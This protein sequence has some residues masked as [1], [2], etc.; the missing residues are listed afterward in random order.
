MTNEVH[1]LIGRHGK[2]IVSD[3]PV[4]K[5]K[6]SPESLAKLYQ[7]GQ[8]DFIY[9]TYPERLSLFTSQRARTEA[10]GKAK[11]AGVLG[12]K[13][14]PQSQDD[15]L[16]GNK[17]P[18]LAQI[19][20][21]Q[22]FGLDLYPGEFSDKAYFDAEKVKSG[23]GGKVCTEFGLRNLDATQHE[24]EDV[25]PF[26]YVLGKAGN[27]LREAIELA[28]T[29]KKDLIQLISHSVITDANAALLVSSD[30]W[31]HNNCLVPDSGAY[32]GH[33][34]EEDFGVLNINYDGTGVRRRKAHFVRRDVAFPV[35][36]I[37]FMNLTS[38]FSVTHPVSLYSP[39]VKK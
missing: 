35:D 6:I 39:P 9:S 16:D 8:R 31:S 22:R 11:F 18:Q 7:E 4:E 30:I 15:V 2:K 25:M 36:I 1:I 27:V 34:E 38:R 13:P 14:V 26:G 28:G 23:L 37:N 12:L 29:G 3:D 10:T 19:D 5:E 24:G 21:N 32:G 17:Y 33:F 20:V